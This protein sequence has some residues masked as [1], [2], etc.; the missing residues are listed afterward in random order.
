MN[1]QEENAQKTGVILKTEIK[2][3]TTLY[4]KDYKKI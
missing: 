1:F 4:A 2:L 3:S